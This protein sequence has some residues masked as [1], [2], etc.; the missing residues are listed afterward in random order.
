DLDRDLHKSV[1]TK[2]QAAKII[3]YQEEMSSLLGVEVFNRLKDESV[4][5]SSNS[6]LIKSIAVDM[7]RYPDNWNG[8]GYLNSF[9]R[10]NWDTSLYKIINLKPG[11]WETKSSS[12]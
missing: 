7:S 11:G 10:E 5:Q 6:E 3:V 8:L 2:E 9:K 4:F 1:L 12:F